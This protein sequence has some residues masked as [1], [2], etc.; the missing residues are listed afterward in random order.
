[1]TLN[2]FVATHTS[3]DNESFNVLQEKT[4]EEHKQRYHWAFDVDEQR[5]DPKLH[6]LS[7]G[8][9]ISKEQ[10]RIVDEVCAPKGLSIHFI[11]AGGIGA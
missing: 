5:G 1:M 4:V 3:E 11:A 10:R 9:W 6:L 7:D 8:T 2:R